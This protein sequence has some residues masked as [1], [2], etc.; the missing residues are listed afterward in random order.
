MRARMRDGALFHVHGSMRSFRDA[1]DDQ[2]DVIERV[3][4]MRDDDDD[5]GDDDGATRDDDDD[6]AGDAT[7]REKEQRTHDWV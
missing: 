5:D 1:T 6:D 3:D 2:H 7:M 4:G